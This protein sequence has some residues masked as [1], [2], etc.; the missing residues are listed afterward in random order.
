MSDR[1]SLSGVVLLFH[2]CI[3]HSFVPSHPLSLTLSFS[4]LLSLLRGFDHFTSCP[5]QCLVLCNEGLVLLRAY[6]VLSCPF[7]CL[8]PCN[9]CPSL[10]GS[11]C[12][13]ML[14]PVQLC[15]YQRSIYW[16]VTIIHTW[17]K[18]LRMYPCSQ[19][20]MF[21][22]SQTKKCDAQCFEKKRLMTLM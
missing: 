9:V 17:K 15:S 4:S 18:Q 10:L 5:L 14:H 1:V 12:L 8:V 19:H 21:A 13:V 16:I 2:P 22:R 11:Y 20:L 3:A 6:S 7:L